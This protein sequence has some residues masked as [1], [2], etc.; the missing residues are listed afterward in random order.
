VKA[1]VFAFEDDAAPAGRL[2]QALGVD[3]APIALHRFP[4]GESLPRVPPPPGTAILYRGLAQ[5][6]AK[7]V[8]LLLSCDALRR[9]GAERLVLVAPYMP[10]LRQDMV[11]RAGEPLSRDVVGGL[12]GLEFQRIVTVEPHLHRTRDLTPVFAGRPV[13]VISAAR[14]LADAIGS[15]G[16]P[17]V[18]GPDAESE[19]WARSV[20]ETLGTDWVVFEKV[21]SGDREVSLS[22]PAEARIEGR[23]VALVDDICSSGATLEAAVRLVAG[24][25]AASVEIAVVHAL[26]TEDAGARLR[27]AG[28][29]KIVST[30]S[31]EHPTNAIRLAG[32]LAAALAEEL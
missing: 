17:L 7:L 32:V 31:C 11:F 27:A 13:A 10:Y 12:I 8:P 4:D 3:L 25:G 14:P 5:P 19:P 26:F 28:A 21:R 23:R 22:L 20:A 18:I 29:S 1:A 9:A 24:R 6:D 30:D 15:E 2:A 16:G